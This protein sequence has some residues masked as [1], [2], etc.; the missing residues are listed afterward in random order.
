MEIP[1]KLY[2]YEFI[3][4]HSI[5]NIKNNQIYFNSPKNFNDPYDC[6]HSIDYK[7]LSLDLIKKL[8]IEANSEGD[9]SVLTNQLFND[10][11]NIESLVELNR[12]LISKNPNLENTLK[13]KLNLTSAQYFNELTTILQD[14][15]IFNEHKTRIST[16]I[17][18]MATKILQK[19]IDKRKSKMANQHGI[20]CFSK[21]FDNMLMWSYY[22]NGHKGFCLEFDTSEEPFN[23][24]REVNYVEGLPP[25]DP[26]FILND[27]RDPEDFIGIFLATK[28]IEWIHEKEWRIFHNESSKLYGYKSRALT[29]IYFGTN[30]D[31]TIKE[32]LLT[33]LHSQNP[34]VRFY[35][36]EKVQNK[37]KVFAKEFY[38]ETHLEGQH[39]F[40]EYIRMNFGE[41]KFSISNMKNLEHLGL[42]TELIEIYLDNLVTLKFLRKD[43]EFYSLVKLK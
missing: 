35:Q 14:E 16:I 34:Y 38:Y 8:F 30:I 10:T 11:I 33:I 42:S 20:C 40:L 29:G 39:K 24:S 43:N 25:F 5:K 31:S 15:T 37:F 32:I 13:K 19:E 18:E 26:S 3:S 21:I 27:K 1:N 12:R 41:K 36:M 22:A 17:S 9:M 6:L 7:P 28:N 23:K 4:E 2:K